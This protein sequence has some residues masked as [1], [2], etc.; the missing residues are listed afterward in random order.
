M[1]RYEK[2]QMLRQIRS[3]RELYC[4]YFLNGVEYLINPNTGEL[5]RVRPGYFGGSHNLATA[6]LQDFIP[7][8]NVDYPPI[9]HLSDG[10]EV[11][12]FRTLNLICTYRINKCRHCFP[13][14][15]SMNGARFRV[16]NQ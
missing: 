8:N 13:D 11:L 12:L 16:S 7:C 9:H 10:E 15:F 2:L 14:E 5:H 6:H 1:T 4:F 3:N